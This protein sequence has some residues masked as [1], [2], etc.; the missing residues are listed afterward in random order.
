[1]WTRAE[2]KQRAKLALNDTYWSAFGVTILAGILEVNFSDVYNWEVL[3][4]RFTGMYPVEVTWP[5]RL[6]PLFMLLGLF[7]TNVIQVGLNHYFIR[8]HYGE[9]QMRN[10]FYGFR[11]SYLN[12][13]GVE[14]VTGFIVFL[15]SLLFIIPGI[16]ASYKYSMVPYLL[17]E[18]PEMNGKE[19]RGL[20]AEM[21]DGQKWDIFVLDL[22]FLGWYLLGLICFIVG[23]LLIPPY[24]YATRAELYIYL[25][26]QHGLKISENNQEGSEPNASMEP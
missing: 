26:D 5:W 13:V 15:W 19:A 24:A 18:N 22:S 16:M 12:I 4:S 7:V 9:T 10:L 25:R 11:R 1:M 8:N 2:L 23:I 20:S 6:F 3:R 14:F 17:S 21:T